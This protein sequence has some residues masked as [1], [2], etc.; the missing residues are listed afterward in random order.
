MI[1]L[2][3]YCSCYWGFDCS[4]KYSVNLTKDGICYYTNSCSENVKCSIALWVVYVGSG[5]AAVIVGSILMLILILCVGCTKK[6]GYSVIRESVVNITPN[7]KSFPL[8]PKA[9]SASTNANP[10]GVNYQNAP[11]N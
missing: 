5:G 8:Q 4:L 6:S 9:Y 10:Y 11:T 3:I 1:F 7:Q 2:G